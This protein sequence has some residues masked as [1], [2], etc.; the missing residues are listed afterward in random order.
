MFSN[1]DIIY[2]NTYV[3]VCV[4][5]GGIGQQYIWWQ[6]EKDHANSQTNIVTDSA[7]IEVNTQF[8]SISDT[9]WIGIGSI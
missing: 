7:R 6:G 9:D 8:G 4:G 1:F 3:C 5:G 2:A